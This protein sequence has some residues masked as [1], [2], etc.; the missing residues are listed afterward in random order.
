M[1][2][3]TQQINYQTLEFDGLEE[4]FL[5]SGLLVVLESTRATR[6]GFGELRWL[7][8]SGK[9]TLQQ[10]EI[11]DCYPVRDVNTDN[12]VSLRAHKWVTVPTLLDN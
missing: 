2:P 6:T 7:E 1:N 10:K 3:Y 4:E 9:K 5:K 8:H 11:W 12:L